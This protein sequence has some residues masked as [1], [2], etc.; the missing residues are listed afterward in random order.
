MQQPDGLGQQ[1]VARMCMHL[2][3]HK[4]HKEGPVPMVSP[5]HSRLTQPISTHATHTR[6]V[7]T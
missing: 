1:H 6:A 4:V 2:L 3:H 7:H 5:T